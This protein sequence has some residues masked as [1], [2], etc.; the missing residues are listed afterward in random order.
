MEDMLITKI[1]P[2]SSNTKMGIDML[3]QELAITLLEKSQISS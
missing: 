1:K 2:I 3:T